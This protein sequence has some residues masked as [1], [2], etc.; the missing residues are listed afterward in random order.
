MAR[1]R[2]RLLQ[3][4][5]SLWTNAPRPVQHTAFRPQIEQLED[6]V[7]PSAAQAFPTYH[8]LQA[9]RGTT[10]Q[11][12]ANPLFNPPGLNPSEVRGAYGI[13]AISFSGGTVTGDGSGQTIAIVD[14]YDDTSIAGDLATFDSQFGI[15]APPNFIKVGVDSSGNGSTTS[16]PSPDSGWA[17]EI[18]LDVEWAHAVA[19]KANILLVEAASSY[20]T[21]L[22]AAVD[23]ARNYTGQFGGTATSVVSMSWGGGEVYGE[24]SNDGHFTTPSGHTGVTFFASSGDSGSPAG[25]P[26]VSSHVVSVGGTTLSTDSAGDYLG[27]S[28]W[29]GSGGGLAQYVSQPSYQN[30]LVVHDGTQVIPANG[31]RAA[32][33]VA[34]VADPNSGV[35][36]YASFGAG[37]WISVG[38]TSA[39]SPQ[40]AA[41]MSIADQGRVLTGKSTLDG[42]TQT[43][44]ELYQLPSTDFHDITSGN[45][46][47]SAGPGF[48]LVTGLGTP[49]ANK[50]VPDIVA[51][52][53][54][55]GGGSSQPPTFTQ[56]AEVTSTSPTAIILF[57]QGTDPAGAQSLT[58]TW[59]LVGS[60]PAPVTFNPNGTNAANAT[61]AT[62]TKAGTYTFQ[63]TITDPS[64]LSATSQVSYTVAQVLTAVTVSPAT[65]TVSDG[66]TKQFSAAT[67]DQFGAAMASQPGFTWSIDSGGLGTVSTTGLYQAPASGSGT[68]TVRAT[69]GGLSGT[70]AVTV[71]AAPTGPT[72]T[73]AAH[74]TAQTPTTATLSVA[75]TDAAGASSLIY[76]WSLSGTSP[77]GVSYSANGSNAAS[78]TTVTFGAVGTYNFVV[79]V[80]DPS[81]LTAA[82]QVTVTVT[83]TLTTIT[84]SPASVTVNDGATQQFSASARD[85]FGAAL[86][87]QPSFTWSIDSGGLGS[88][89]TTGLYQ[90]P[91][92]GNGGATVRATSGSV[93]GTATVSVSAAPSGPTITTGAHIVSQTPTTATLSVAATD[94]A[95]AS[96]LIYTWALTG[97]PPG[98]VYASANGTNAASTTT[99][100]FTAVGTY[101]FVVTVKD[102]SNL[103]A[104]SQVTVTVTATL[105]TITV[106]PASVT[107]NDGATQQFSAVAKDQFGAVM[108]SQPSFGW[109]IDSGGLGSVSTTGLYQ[110]PASGSGGATV[111][112]ASGSVSGTATVSVATSGPVIPVITTGAHVV[113]QTPTTATLSVSAIDAAGPSQLTY[114][115]YLTGT[116]PGPVTASVN[117]TNAASTTTMTFSAAGTYNFVVYVRDPSGN[118]AISG[119]TVTVSSVLTSI[120]LTPSTVTLATGATQ[121][122]QAS[123]RNQFGQAMTSP[124]G[125]SWSVT[126]PGSIGSTGVFT[127]GSG[128]ATVVVT[129]GSVKAQA[130][131][132]VPTPG[133]TL[134]FSAPSMPAP[135]WAGYATYS[136]LTV[137][138]DVTIGSLS[139]TL[140]IGFPYDGYL[141]LD[142]I[143]PQGIDIPLSYFR[144]SGSGFLNTTFSD[145]ASLGIFQGFAP[146]SGSF[147]PEKALGAVAGLDARGTWTLVVSDYGSSYGQ[148]NSWSVTIQ[149]TAPAAITGLFTATPTSGGTNSST[150]GYFVPPPTHS[151]DAGWWPPQVFAPSS[152]WDPWND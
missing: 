53:P 124:P 125:F 29:S 135:I 130:S 103:T 89:S 78:T 150:A 151:G 66:A 3:R 143:S 117:G 138:Q 64:G 62:F 120:T 98:T 111:R 44:P 55:G 49:V 34:L 6:M 92:S 139:V 118:S 140:N 26:S 88:V 104:T 128:N 144:G 109:S 149:P 142:L 122:F 96:A 35:A 8:I 97:T 7:L 14:A 99:M 12:S 15:A 36:V 11:P 80:K 148:V 19:P 23:F 113:T 22:L 102:P 105:T 94:P 93:S 121:A 90:A 86:A 134:T 76:T 77:A 27:E 54:S 24:S 16:L 5:F 59:S 73:T 63:V 2:V 61:Q 100:T 127:A 85:Q 21:D 13:N 75:A 30:G 50:L 95:G 79:T 58:Y 123:G 107:V 38:G 46:G 101:N 146:F 40:W 114:T 47:Y 56:V 131:I 112:A 116:A 39:A 87:S 110:A 132:T 145:Q 25:W 51:S 60:A 42:Y 28:G 43:L 81:N 126:G 129:S 10:A 106:S 17:V 69:G 72:I 119:V 136:H 9:A 31:A 115:W 137:P 152:P 91:A 108:A 67:T 57:A 32:P 70:A 83:A 52:N 20:D 48:D 4:I 33:D 68:A 41:L 71:T 141:A 65:A 147:R 74:V 18:A 84:V 45:N 133:A 82:S 37:G 1:I